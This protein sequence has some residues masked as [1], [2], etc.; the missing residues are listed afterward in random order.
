MLC[1]EARQGC[2]V[3]HRL[4]PQIQAK[5]HFSTA[6]CDVHTA[7]APWDRVDYD[8][9]V[10][11]AGTLSAVFYAFGEIML[12]QKQAWNG[13]VYSEGNNHAFYCGLTDGNYGQDQAYRPADNPWL[14]DFDLRKLHDLCCNFGMGSPDMFYAG[15]RPSQTTP[16]EKDAWLDRFL[17]ATVAFGHPG[18]LVFEGGTKNA[19]RSYYMLQQLHSRYCLA[20]AKEIRYADASGLLLDTSTAVASGAFTRSQIVTRYSDGTVTAAN[21]HRSERMKVKANGRDLDLPPNGYCGWTDDGSIDVWSRDLDGQRADYADTPAYLYIDGRHHFVRAAKAA[22][23]GIGICRVLPDAYEILL[24]D[25]AECGFAVSAGSAKALA[26]DG[27][28]LG[29]A[30]LRKARGLAYVVPVAG[31]FSYMLTRGPKSIGDTSGKGPVALRCDRTEVRPGERVT[32]HGKES[33]PLVIPAKS[34]DGE[35]LWFELEGGWIDFTVR[36]SG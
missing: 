32:V 3:L 14:V 11:G 10:P 12:L 34:K 25:G 29:P 27:R 7:V 20:S 36:G 30:R 13:P 31:A 35:R 4:A 23:N 16:D 28:A 22:G 19:L 8:A 24:H 18:F 2:G 5:F 26:A 6:Y 1:P 21:G 9:R 17:A 15:K 33:H